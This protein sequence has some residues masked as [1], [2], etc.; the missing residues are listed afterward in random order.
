LLFSALVLALLLGAVGADEVRH[1]AMLGLPA[2]DFKAEYTVNGKFDGLA[3][4]KSKVVLLV[5]GRLSKS[6]SWNILS[7]AE[8][9]Y[10]KHKVDQLEVFVI[11]VF[12]YKAEEQSRWSSFDPIEGKFLKSKTAT[13]EQEAKVLKAFMADRK[14]RYPLLRVAPQEG[15]KILGD[16]YGVTRIPQTV[17]IDRK[18]VVRLVRV[19]DGDD[20]IQAI[21]TMLDRLTR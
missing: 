13:L 15:R 4:L 12:D 9:W 20:K 11:P 21:E 14:L 7:Q 5:F 3:R 8:A 19:G 10:M 17:L 2:P 6:P 1:E 16:A 18:G